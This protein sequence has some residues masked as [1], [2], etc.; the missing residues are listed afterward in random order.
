LPWAC[1]LDWG[2]FAFLGGRI[3]CGDV[4]CLS[5]SDKVVGLVSLSLGMFTLVIYVYDADWPSW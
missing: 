3:C 1:V 5:N 4:P 2:F